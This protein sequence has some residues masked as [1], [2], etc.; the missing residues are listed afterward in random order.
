[1][2]SDRLVP[3]AVISHC[4]TGYARAANLATRSSSRSRHPGH[5]SAV[6]EKIAESRNRPSSPGAQD[7]DQLRRT[8][9]K[10]VPTLS[11]A[12]RERALRASVLRSTRETC[13]SS[14]AC[15]NSSSL[16]SALMPVPWAGPASQV[17]PISM[18][19]SRSSER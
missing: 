8:P 14:K 17:K 3:D 6:T 7:R 13:H 10:R 12:A 9:S 19:S 11:I 4:G 18:A 1:M 16:A 2:I 15:R 5:S